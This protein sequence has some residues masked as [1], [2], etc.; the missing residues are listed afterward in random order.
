MKFV[1]SSGRHGFHVHEFGDISNKCYKSGGIFNPT[2]EVHGGPNSSNR[3]A[4]DFGNI[5]ANPFGFAKVLIEIPRGSSLFGTNTLIDRTLVIHADEDTLDPTTTFGNA[6]SRLACGIIKDMTSEFQNTHNPNIS[7]EDSI[8]GEE[9]SEYSYYDEYSEYSEYTEYNDI[10]DNNIHSDNNAN[11]NNAN[12][13]NTNINNANNDNDNQ[14]E[15][16]N[17]NNEIN[18]SNDISNN[19][20]DSNNS[21]NNANQSE[22]NDTNHEINNS[23]DNSSNSGSNSSGFIR[24]SGR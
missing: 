9:Y 8:I 19:N 17:S 13:E 10:T 23:N 12:N 7:E 1:F 3:H 11:I 18:N 5:E 24:I 22:N 16:N 21:N 4:G 6:G 15:N 2:N 20:G 14:S